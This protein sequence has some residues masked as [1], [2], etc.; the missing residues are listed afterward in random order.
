MEI[1]HV[2]TKITGDLSGA[3]IWMRF[4]DNPVAEKALA[5]VELKVPFEGLFLTE[6]VSPFLPGTY[7]HKRF[8]IAALQFV[9]NQ[10]TAEIERLSEPT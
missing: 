5:T 8:Q 7:Q 4:A 2:E 6:P 10:L 9:R 3:V 1:K